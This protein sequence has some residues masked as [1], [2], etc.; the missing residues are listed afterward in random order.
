MNH[1]E[2]LFEV[3][4][5]TIIITVVLFI[6]AIYMKDKFTLYSTECILLIWSLILP[7]IRFLNKC[8]EDNKEVKWKKKT[9][10][11]R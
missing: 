3:V 10:K 11:N 5:R 9:Q 8:Y 4:S 2:W 1:F 6:L 7:T